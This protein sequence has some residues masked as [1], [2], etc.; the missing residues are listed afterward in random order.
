MHIKGTVAPP[1]TL[2][3]P[4]SAGSRQRK[5]RNYQPAKVTEADIELMPA[6]NF[7]AVRTVAI[8]CRDEKVQS[9]QGSCPTELP[10]VLPVV[11]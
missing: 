2:E 7:S 3:T 5:G 6:A 8:I 4:G 9:I 11:M 1:P 10:W